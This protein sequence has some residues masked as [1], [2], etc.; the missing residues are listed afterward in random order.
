MRKIVA[1]VH[2][3]DGAMLASGGPEGLVRK[4]SGSRPTAIR[5]QA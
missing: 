2:D 4:I 1:H 5:M 3:F